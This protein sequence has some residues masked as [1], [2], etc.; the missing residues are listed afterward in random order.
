MVAVALGGLLGSDAFGAHTVAQ[1]SNGRI[2]FAAVG[3]IASMNPDG[4][5][6]WGVE[7]NVGDSAPAWSPYGSQLPVTTH[8]RRNNDEPVE[9]GRGGSPRDDRPGDMDGM[10]AAERDCLANGSQI[11]A[12]NADG[13]SRD[14]T[15]GD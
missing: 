13:S 1:H 2:A 10:V 4:S 9:P 14:V 6:Q 5:G 8:W 11:W 12:V 3:G 7:L 15:K